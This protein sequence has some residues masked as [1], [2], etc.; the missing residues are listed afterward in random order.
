MLSSEQVASFNEQ[1]YLRIPQMFTPEQMDA[2]DQDLERLVAE[3]AMTSPG[4]TGPWRRVYMDE[5]TEKASTLTA[6]HDL[7]FYSQAWMQGVTE[8]RLT[9]AVSDILGSNVELHHSTLHIKPPSAGHPFPMH[10]D[11]PFYMHDDGRYIDVLVHLDDTCHENG[12]IRFLAG[13][14]KQGALKHI[15]QLEDGSGCTPHLPTDQYSLEETV[16]VPAKRGDVVFFSIHTIHGSHINQTDKARRMVR[17]GY[18]N[19]QNTQTAGQSHGRPGLMV[20]GYRDRQDG[21]EVLR[22]T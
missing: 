16:A 13:S 21:Q 7:Y 14:H 20:R 9:E 5:K 15:T 3:W 8:P 2:L 17:V 4:W 1:G 19:P 12:E 22:N 11:H 6:M 18:R 10:Q